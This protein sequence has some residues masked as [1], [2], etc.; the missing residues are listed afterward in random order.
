MMDS[1]P[2][3]SSTLFPQTTSN[4]NR[5]PLSEIPITS[6]SQPLTLPPSVFEIPEYIPEPE[7]VS[8]FVNYRQPTAVKIISQQPHL[9]I[10]LIPNTEFLSPPSLQLPSETDASTRSNLYPPLK[11][12]RKPSSS[13]SNLLETTS[14]EPD[15]IPSQE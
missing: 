10:V 2:T 4:T 3:T 15:Y 9:K 14:Q 5:P 6:R 11:P 7:T 13:L 12:L 8:W 1:S